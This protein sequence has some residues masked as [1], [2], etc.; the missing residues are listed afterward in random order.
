M[1][2]ER[3]SGLCGK[4]T[5]GARTGRRILGA[6]REGDAAPGTSDSDREYQ[7]RRRARRRAPRDAAR[8]ASD[9]AD[10]VAGRR[11]RALRPRAAM[12]RPF[13]LIGRWRRVQ[14][15][16]EVRRSPRLDPGTVHPAGVT[17][18]LKVLTSSAASQRELVRSPACTRNQ[19]QPSDPQKSDGRPLQGWR[20]GTGGNEPRTARAEGYC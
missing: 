5:A 17:T 13:A 9:A 1:T 3:A 15:R 19:I 6:Q 18:A 16:A 20:Q 10:C 4:R 11:L 2:W 14:R 8:Y 7:P 12:R